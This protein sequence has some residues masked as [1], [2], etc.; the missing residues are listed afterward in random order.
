MLVKRGQRCQ[1]KLSD[2]IVRK[3]AGQKAERRSA[4][5]AEGA[6]IYGN[7]KKEAEDRNCF[8]V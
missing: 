5:T 8:R 2:K 6:C 7:G 3:N 1:T 4:A